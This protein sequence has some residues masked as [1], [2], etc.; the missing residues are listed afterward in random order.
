MNDTVNQ[1]H[2]YP[3]AVEGFEEAL[4]RAR[5]GKI[6]A[7]AMLWV[8]P[9]GVIGWKWH[10]GARPQTDMVGGVA[11]MQWAITTGVMSQLPPPESEPTMPKPPTSTPQ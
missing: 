10:L 4:E 1:A 3:R 6:A 5:A 9:N 11:C 8:D 2:P 7:F